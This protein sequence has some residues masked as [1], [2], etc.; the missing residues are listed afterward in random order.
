MTLET[1]IE[2]MYRAGKITIPGVAEKVSG[3][4]QSLHG[5][6]PTFDVQAALAGDPA[7]L[8]ATLSMCGE[9]HEAL[10]QMT[11]T[12]NN[13]AGAV[14]ATAD[15]FR[16]T[17]EGAARDFERMDPNLR[18]SSPTEAVEVPGIDDPS[19]PGATEVSYDDEHGSGKDHE[20]HIEPTPPPTTTE[21]DSAD[22]RDDQVGPVDAPEE[23]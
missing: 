23:S 17:D 8:R 3:V 15:D 19:A 1:P 5:T 21:L 10:R 14:V 4:A 12:L 13:C 22:E 7:G 2:A 18:S 20:E 11:V 6:I 9:L 16:R